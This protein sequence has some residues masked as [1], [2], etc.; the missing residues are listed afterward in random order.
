MI[1]IDGNKGRD[2]HHTTSGTIGLLTQAWVKSNRLTSIFGRGEKAAVTSV[3][4]TLTPIL[5]A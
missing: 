5:T 3:F 1:K 4:I 2:F